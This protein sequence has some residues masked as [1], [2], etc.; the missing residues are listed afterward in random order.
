MQW[1]TCQKCVD[2]WKMYYNETEG[3]KGERWIHCTFSLKSFQEK[4][5]LKEGYNHAFSSFSD[6][7]LK[8]CITIQTPPKHKRRAS[9][10]SSHQSWVCIFFPFLC[11]LCPPDTL[12]F[13]ILQWAMLNLSSNALLCVDWLHSDTSV[14]GTSRTSVWWQEKC[15]RVN[16]RQ[17]SSLIG[18]FLSLCSFPPHY[19][20]PE[21][22]QCWTI[23]WQVAWYGVRLRV[24]WT[25]S[26]GHTNQHWRD[27]HWLRNRDNS[28]P[29]CP[30]KE[31]CDTWPTD[32]C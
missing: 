17:V 27:P 19:W 16:Q 23:N 20:C 6:F 26:L 31:P 3:E 5:W 12:S 21:Q 9:V 14:C 1:E 15:S 25:F 22:S 10:S 24:Q 13:S 8:N 7:F 18:S 4:Y 32:P 30:E 2:V 28:G 29:W 11:N